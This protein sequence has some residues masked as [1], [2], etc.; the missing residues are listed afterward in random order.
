MISG[1]QPHSGDVRL[2]A[3]E[4]AFVERALLY[5]ESETY[6]TLFPPLEGRK[7]VPVDNKAPAGAKFTTYKQYTRTGIARI[8][9]ERGLDLPTSSLF[10]KEFSHPFFRLGMS[11]EYTLDDMLAAQ[12]SASQ[13]QPLNLDLENALACKEGIEKKLDNIA[14]VGSSDGLQPSIGLLGLLNQ[15]NATTYTVANGATGSQAWTSK[16]PD[17][18][19][20]DMTGI[21]ASMISATYKVFVPDTMLLPITQYET[22]AGRSMGDGR[23]DTILS[24]FTKISRHITTIDSWQFCAGAGSGST[25]RMVVYRKDPRFVRHM[26]SQEFTQMPPRFENFVF[27]TECTAKT[28]GVVC[29]Y[30]LSVSYG[31]GI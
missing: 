2:D 7:Y 16:T 23:S 9:T 6:N 30:P 18:I 5:V 25:D 29:P 17:E 10:V 1:Y 4:S 13:G 11:Y 20:A 28:A 31:D 27:T 19:I 3:A 24:Y 26:I 8:V 14:R 12:M 22:I 21:V 15:T